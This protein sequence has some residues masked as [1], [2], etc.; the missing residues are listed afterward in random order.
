MCG[1]IEAQINLPLNKP[2]ANSVTYMFATKK[3]PQR[4]SIAAIKFMK[5]YTNIPYETP[6]SGGLHGFQ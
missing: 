6:E 1:L 4:T 2:M 3:D 5:P